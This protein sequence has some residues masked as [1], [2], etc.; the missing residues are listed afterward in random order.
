MRRGHPQ[1]VGGLND[2]VASPVYATAVGL[3]LWGAI[4]VALLLLEAG[5]VSKDRLLQGIALALPIV[6][7]RLS[8]PVPAP[9]VPHAEFLSQFMSL[10]GSPVWMTAWGVMVFY[11]YATLRQVPWAGEALQASLLLA[12]CVSP[13]TVNL[14]RL[15]PIQVWPLWPVALVQAIR[16]IETRNSIRCVVAALCATAAW[17]ACGHR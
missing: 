6:C 4:A 8:T 13:S 17:P 15:G 14:H 9:S 12:T 5:L 1:S 7:L 3:L 16:G 11:A 2:V 10:S